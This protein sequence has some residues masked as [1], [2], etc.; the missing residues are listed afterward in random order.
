M[1]SRA[2]I[3]YAASSWSRGKSKQLEMRKHNTTLADAIWG[4]SV[5]DNPMEA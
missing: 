1:T 5:T 2:G 3:A 4:A